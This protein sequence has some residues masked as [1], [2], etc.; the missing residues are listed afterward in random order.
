MQT[1]KINTIDGTTIM[2]CD[3]ITISRKGWR[4]FE[5]A[6]DLSKKNGGTQPDS[7]IH[8]AEVKEGDDGINCISQDEVIIAERY[9]SPSELIGVVLIPHEDED[10]V[11]YQF[12]Y[13]G[14]S[15]YIMNANGSTVETLK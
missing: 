11:V 10:S 6:L 14:D 15:V 13:Q 1:V 7:I 2:E 9:G 12:I 5:S 8:I 4:I 3:S